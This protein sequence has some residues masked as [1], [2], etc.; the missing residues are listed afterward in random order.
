MIIQ[1]KR[2]WVLGQ[3]I[4][5]QLELEDGK[6]KNVLA[7]GAKPAD[8]DYGERRI[9]PGF[10]D[11]HTHGAYGFDTNDAEEEGLRNWMKHIPE[12]G[13]TGICPTTITQTEE[14]LTKAVKNVAKVV[15]D[16]YEGAEI[17]GIHFEGPYLDMVY[18]GAQPEQC[19]VKPDVE[20]FKRYQKAADGLIKIITMA[21]ERDEDF[22][23][24]RYC[25]A[26]DVRVS[27]GHS[28]ATIEEA[29]MAIANGATSMTHIFNGMTPF[30]HR[31]P[32]LV[33]AAMRFRDT[34]GEVICDG[35]HSTPDALNDLF[36]AK[37]RDYTIMITDALMV[38]GLPVGTKVLFGGNEIELYPDG[39]AHLTD[40][41]SLAGSTLK[42][43]EG[44]K[45]LVEKAMIP[46]DYA[47]N[48]CTLN[49]ARYL[50]VDDRKGK[51][52]SGYDADI[53][54]LNDD[55]SVEMT[56]VRGKEAF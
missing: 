13:V 19:I 26:N 45:V 52:V 17:L 20:Q 3:F 38:K 48:S 15:A 37:G 8:K 22:E 44:L 43:N 18:K 39:S 7:Y 46:W 32:G 49:P 10:I 53:V 35:N 5:A 11:V 36:M 56:Y 28:A 50:N 47:I 30:H 16:G 31:K 51:L 14:V 33:G 4:E 24:T 55:Y 6:I 42:V 27:I 34:F 12:E 9:V 40:A 41:K 1:S 23:L 2:I 25:A 54:V 29:G 21:T